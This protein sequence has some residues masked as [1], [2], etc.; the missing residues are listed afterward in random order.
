MQVEKSSKLNNFYK[1]NIKLGLSFLF[2]IAV[3]FIF[4][5]IFIFRFGQFDEL[6]GFY[7]DLF[8]A[9]VVGFR[10]DA[11]VIAYGLV[12]ILLLNFSFT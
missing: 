6:T 2:F 12:G 9:I 1:Q 11:Q 10:F 5:L 3:F 8:K 7:G 4:R